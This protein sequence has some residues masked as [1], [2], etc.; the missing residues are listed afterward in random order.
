[1]FTFRRITPSDRPAIQ[2]IA[3]RTWEGADYLS[4]VFDEWV[5][6]DRGEF[7]AVLLDGKLV[8]CG[9]MTYLTPTDVWFEGLRKDPTAS[10]NGVASAL[11]S[12]F[13]SLLSGR[14]EITSIRFSTYFKNLQSIA[15]NERLGFHCAAVFSRKM[16]E[17]RKEDLASLAA[18]RSDLKRAAAGD[19]VARLSDESLVRRFVESSGWYG[20]NGAL[21]TEGWKAYSYSGKLFA[22]RYV[23]PGFCWGVLRG[24]EI[25]GLSVFLPDTRFPYTHMKIVFL[26]ARDVSTADLL[27]DHIVSFTLDQASDEVKW[28]IVLPPIPRVKKYA[29][30]RGFTSD[31]RDDDYRVYE[32]PLSR[33]S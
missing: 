13:L 24:G 15:S 1:M 5:S 30:K 6:D 21:I 23:K 9:K 11:T 4:Y 16:W 14:R 17:G 27:I 28:E 2:A 10:V 26:D 7:D 18:G 12:H 33:L 20:D 22:E 19:P 31:E 25:S 8:G 32:F 29:E 3:A